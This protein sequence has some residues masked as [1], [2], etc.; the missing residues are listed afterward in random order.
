M[1]QYHYHAQG[2]L[3]HY[4][5]LLAQLPNLPAALDVFTNK[6]AVLAYMLDLCAHLVEVCYLYGQGDLMVTICKQSVMDVARPTG[7]PLKAALPSAYN[8]TSSKAHTFL[9]ECQ[10]FMHLN[11]TSFPNDQVKILWV[12]QLCSDKAANWKRIQTELLEMG[13][14]VPDHLLDWDAFQKEFLL[15]WADLNMQDKAQAKFAS[16]LKQ[17]T[18]VCHYAKPFKETVLEADFTDPVML[19]VAFYEGLKWEIKQLLIGR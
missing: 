10:T 18:S 12:L 19:T 16:G 5:D 7:P 17:T 13:V 2:Y 15:K 14:S 8:S 6:G 11:Q 4:P 1:I 3:A 9:M